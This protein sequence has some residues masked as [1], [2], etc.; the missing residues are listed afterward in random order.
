MSDRPIFDTD[1][2]LTDKVG[3]MG[4]RELI[5]LMKKLRKQAVVLGA[6]LVS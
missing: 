2:R 3:G 1:N 4:R 5:E 6:N